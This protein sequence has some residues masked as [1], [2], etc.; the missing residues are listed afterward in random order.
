MT[1]PAHTHG[2]GT[3]GRAGRGLPFRHLLARLTPAERAAWAAARH[4]GG[5]AIATLVTAVIL[6]GAVARVVDQADALNARGRP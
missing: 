3:G 6:P 4:A 2:T 5:D 1:Y